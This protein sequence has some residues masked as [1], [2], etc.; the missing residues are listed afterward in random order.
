M[1][2]NLA[3]A[4]AATA[5]DGRRRRVETPSDVRQLFQQLPIAYAWIGLYLRYAALTVI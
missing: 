3:V 5:A 1:E 4:A 2:P